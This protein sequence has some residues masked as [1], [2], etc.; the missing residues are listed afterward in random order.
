MGNKQTKKRKEIIRA[1]KNYR[2]G[3]PLMSDKEFDSL[4]EKYLKKYP[5]DKELAGVLGYKISRKEELPIPMMSL[6]K[7]K[8]YEEVVKW[9]NA[10]KVNDA[11][12]LVLSGKMDGISLVLKEYKEHC[13][14]RG[15]GTVGQRSHK[16]FKALG[17][18]VAITDNTTFGEAIISRENWEK[19]FEGKIN[20]RNKKPYR[21]PRNTVAGLF[22]SDKIVPEL[23]YVD[24]VRYGMDS[25]KTK[26]SIMTDLGNISSKTADY[27][28]IAVGDFKAL[29]NPVEYLDK[30]YNELGKDYIIDG[31]VIDLDDQGFGREKREANGNPTF[32]RAIKLSHWSEQDNSDTVIKKKF[33]KISK[34][35]KLKGVVCF[36]PLMV[37]GSEV[38]QASFY[39]AKFLTQFVLDEGRKIKVKKSG[40]IIPKI[41]EVE[42]IRI[43]MREDYKSTKEFEKAL[44][45]CQGQVQKKVG[46]DEF[47]KLSDEIAVCPSCGEP[48][49][50]DATLTEL[51]CKNK[52]KCPGIRL[53][54]IVNFF[55]KIGIEEFGEKEISKLYDRGYDTIEKIFFIEKEELMEI[56]G[57]GKKSIKT[58]LDQFKEVQKEKIPL[59]RILDAVDLFDGKIGEKTIQTILDNDPISQYYEV[60]KLCEMKGVSEITANVFIKG[61]KRYDKINKKWFKKYPNSEYYLDIIPSYI[62]TPKVEMEGYALQNMHVCFT[63]VRDEDLEV[64][65]VKNGGA[66]TN[67]VN[68]LTTH[69]IVPDLE[70]KTM[71]TK[72][73]AA[74]LANGISIMVL[75][76]FKEEFM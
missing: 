58:L 60:G 8:T 76:K 62:D 54:K 67:S 43:P 72:K 26:I 30:L 18:E 35:G 32:A 19:H 24:Y 25:E 47:E 37:E 14:T 66:L 51:V 70:P 13:W 16:H 75:E 42:G 22:N 50:W 45:Y 6:D 31:L 3:K 36:D 17:E 71:S 69:L 21:V 59:A 39:N 41:I 57:W 23:K 1:N 12:F 27:R 53:M 48:L 7:L 4:L 73:A 33:F 46:Q 34:Q 68:K 74:A 61:H 63:G 55:L 10:N 2:K 20:P 15:D 56:D 40:D 49:D 64:A 29:E 44:E 38:K 9:L 28:V 5:D 52:K 65:I 11:A